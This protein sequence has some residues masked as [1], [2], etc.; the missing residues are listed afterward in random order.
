[1]T[2]PTTDPAP[3]APPPAAPDSAATTPTSA[4]DA[5]AALNALTA[6]K[7]WGKALMNGNPAARKQFD[8][9]T[10]AIANVSND[11]L[12]R[13][14]TEA[15]DPLAVAVTGKEESPRNLRD[16]IA[17]LKTLGLSDA[18][19]AEAIKGSVNSSEIYE[20]CLQLQRSRHGDKEWV[21][22]YLAGDYAAV[23]EQTLMSIVLSG[24]IRE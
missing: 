10:R 13:E 2:E 12:A 11:V 1:M 20:E 3:A 22:K 19:T 15:T 18:A 6:D 4:A 17:H 7:E 9:L 5:Q 24:A 14:T 8:D 16:A 21:K 23:R